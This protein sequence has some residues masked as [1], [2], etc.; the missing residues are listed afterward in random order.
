ME[1]IPLEIETITLGI[2]TITLGIETITLGM[3]SSRR[4][5]RVIRLTN[6]R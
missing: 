6:A 4:R 2:E 1:T 3:L 5:L